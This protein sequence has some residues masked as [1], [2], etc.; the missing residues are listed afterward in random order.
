[1]RYKVLMVLMVVALT[2]ASVLPSCN[3]ELPPVEADE[4]VIPPSLDTVQVFNE[5]ANAGPRIGL[6]PYGYGQEA[7]SAEH[8]DPYAMP[9]GATEEQF[10]KGYLA[11]IPESKYIK[12]DGKRAGYGWFRLVSCIIILKYENIKSA[13]RSFVN[14]SETQELQDSTY[15]GIALKNG[16]Y[17]LAPRWEQY[18][19]WD[20]S[21]MPCYL[22]HS[23]SSLSTSM[24]GKMFLMI[25]WTGLLLRSE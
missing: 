7:W 3:E 2:M 8:M 9:Q 4:L 13:E 6:W 14:I 23:G 1:M 18:D 25:C 20:E 12:R 17:T 15:G 19:Y 21:T 16:T 10:S 5:T 11:V 24:V 22:I